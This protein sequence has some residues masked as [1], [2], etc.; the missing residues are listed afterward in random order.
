M[1][2]LPGFPDSAD[3]DTSKLHEAS[4]RWEFKRDAGSGGQNYGQ[5]FMVP[6]GTVLVDFEIHETSR[7]NTKDEPDI[8]PVFENRGPLRL[9][10]GVHVG[11]RLEPDDFPGG[12]GA[13]FTG[14]IK[15]K[16]VTEIDWMNEALSGP[17]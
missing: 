7:R 11:I 12:A 13:G 1:S 9:P 16:V 3:F 2:S 10:N 6:E 14:D 8:R 17:H 15:M 5:D 4:A